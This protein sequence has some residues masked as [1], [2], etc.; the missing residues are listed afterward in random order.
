[1]LRACN[2]RLETMFEQLEQIELWPCALSRNTLSQMAKLAKL[3]CVG[4]HPVAWLSFSVL[5]HGGG[6]WTNYSGMVSDSKF[7]GIFRLRSLAPNSKAS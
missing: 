6:G 2:A 5:G 1:M 3:L 4:A 7:E